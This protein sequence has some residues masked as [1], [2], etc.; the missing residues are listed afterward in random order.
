LT[1]P[2][3]QV[4]MGS[5]T[6]DSKEI[7]IFEPEP[8][9]EEEELLVEEEEKE[10]QEEEAMTTDLNPEAIWFN[11]VDP[12]ATKCTEREIETQLAGITKD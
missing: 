10:E 6:D 8:E 5:R 12:K 1:I 7:V 3:E 2:V 9:L 4:V 11:G